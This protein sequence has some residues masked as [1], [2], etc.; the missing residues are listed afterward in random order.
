M[1]RLKL[2]SRPL[3]RFVLCISKLVVFQNVSTDTVLKCIKNKS[4]SALFIEV[5]NRKK[6][7]AISMYIIG[8][9]INVGSKL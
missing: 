1:I 3:Q 5:L 4:V 2:P 7:G 8:F 9:L 6:R